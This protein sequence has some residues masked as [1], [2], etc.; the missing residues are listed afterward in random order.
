MHCFRGAQGGA[1]AACL[2][3]SGCDINFKLHSSICVF[4]SAD[5]CAAQQT[6]GDR[7]H[8]VCPA[9][10]EQARRLQRNLILLSFSQLEFSLFRSCAH[11]HFSP[12]QPV[13]DSL[14]IRTSRCRFD[15][16]RHQV[17]ARRFCRI[18][19]QPAQPA[20]KPTRNSGS[21]C[22]DAV[23]YAPLPQH[24]RLVPGCPRRSRARP[25]GSRGNDRPPRR[26]AR[27]SHKPQSL[28]CFSSHLY[29]SSPRWSPAFRRRRRRERTGSPRRRSPPSSCSRS[30]PLS[31]ARSRRRRR[32]C[33]FTALP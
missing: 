3:M 20:A 21:S 5:P 31:P 6:V 15:T 23:R 4:S 17:R 7:H 24:P 13:H 14:W 32:A 30:P 12:P 28:L 19:W 33:S 25:H 16:R 10:S 29:C 1:S 11:S 18:A 9:A 2:G 22:S 8:P 27:T 26:G